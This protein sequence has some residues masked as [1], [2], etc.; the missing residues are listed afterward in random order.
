MKIIGIGVDLLALDRIKGLVG[1]RG[2][3][4]FARRILSE[5]ERDLLTQTEDKL[6]FLQSRWAVKEA[7]FK[8]ASA[9]RRLL[10]SEV[11]VVKRNDG[12]PVILFEQDSMLSSHVTSYLSF[13]VLEDTNTRYNTRVTTGIF[14]GCLVASTPIPS[15]MARFKFDHLPDEYELPVNDSPLPLQQAIAS[16]LY[17]FHA[18]KLADDERISHL[19]GKPFDECR[20][21]DIKPNE[22]NILRVDPIV[23]PAELELISTHLNFFWILPF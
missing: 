18:F 19:N 6:D 20:K 10:W 11:S 14:G 5:R 4:P 9:E 22:L 3:E 8:A 16:L 21:A 2:I 23:A 7:L 12:R 13:Y 1:R 15:I 17:S